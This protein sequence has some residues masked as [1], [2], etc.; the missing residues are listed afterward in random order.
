M[1]DSR[2]GWVKICNDFSFSHLGSYAFHWVLWSE[3]GVID[4]GNFY[5]DIA[6]LEYA[7][8]QVDLPDFFWEDHLEYFLDFSVILQTLS[9]IH[10]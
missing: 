6:P 7:L 4:K 2:T 9:L 8:I 10:I 5:A 3:K 1:V